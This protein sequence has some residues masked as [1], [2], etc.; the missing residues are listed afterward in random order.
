[1]NVLNKIPII[2][3]IIILSAAGNGCMRN[4]A[5]YQVTPVDNPVYMPN[6]EFQLFEDLTLP[7]FEHLIN[8]YQ[9]DTVIAGESDEFKRMLLLRNW[10]KSV[11]RIE[12]HSPSYSGDGYAEAIL[13]AALKGEGFHCA[14][15]MKVQNAIFNAYGYVTRVIGAGPG[16]KG[17]PDGNHGINEVWSNKFCKWFLSDAKYN[18]HFE[19]NGIPL[20]ALEVRH[21]YLKNKTADIVLVKGP[22]R[23]PIEFDKE[24]EL[25]KERFAQTYTWI[26]WNKFGNPHSFYPKKNNEFIMVYQDDYY[27]NNTYYR[28]GAPVDPDYMATWR[29]IKNRKSI[30]W[31][32]NVLNIST[33]LIG[34]T[35]NIQIISE[36]PNLKE[37]QIKENM[38]GSWKKVEAQINLK[39]SKNKHLWFFRSVNFANV[40]GPES[41]LIVEKKES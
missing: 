23:T 35:V 21:E 32:P 5:T 37:Y 10:M 20:S 41:K 36:T 8:K 4:K 14:H 12:D 18:H 31:S 30:E 24:F 16:V 2:S 11:I 33:K 9:L 38:N 29:K 25:S 7:R 3:L 27:N 19:K 40:T 6:T 34:D 13:D 1:M 26:K 15:F 28:S 39:L 17:G 22:N